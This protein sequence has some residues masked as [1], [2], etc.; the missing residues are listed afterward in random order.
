MIASHCC[1]LLAHN[2]PQ[3]CPLPFFP[4]MYVMNGSQLQSKD[5]IHVCIYYKIGL[6]NE[7]ELVTCVR[8]LWYPQMILAPCYVLISGFLETIEFT[9][10]GKCL[11]ALIMAGF[12]GSS[13]F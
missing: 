11:I 3:I 4:V 10:T 2:T 5:C 12:R 1:K 8:S 9:W 6:T 7:L 13:A